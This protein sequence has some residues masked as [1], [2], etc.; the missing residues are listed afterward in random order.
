MVLR[1]SP[2]RIV[3]TGVF[4]QGTSQEVIPT[5]T[6]H[7]PC[8]MT[9]AHRRK[10]QTT[11]LPHVVDQNGGG[12]RVWAGAAVPPGALNQRT[13]VKELYD[14]RDCSLLGVVYDT[15]RLSGSGNGTTRLEGKRNFLIGNVSHFQA[16]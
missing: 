14:L 10:L 7:R 13:G 3:N 11:L 2:K 12:K 5:D 8:L 9:Q 6:P 4:A 16:R 1:W 15:E